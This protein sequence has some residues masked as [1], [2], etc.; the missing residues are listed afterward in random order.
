MRSVI[1]I[2]LAFGCASPPSSDAGLASDAG[3]RSDAR[4]RPDARID[5]GRVIAVG[6]CEALGDVGQWEEITPPEVSLPGPADCPFG[7]N[8]F[9]VDPVN[10][11]TV[12]LGT[13]NQGIWKST[14]CGS[15]WVHINTGRGAEALDR[16]RQWTFAIDPTQ[17]D[18]LYTN[19][20]YGGGGSNGFFKSTNGGVDW[21]EIW[22]P[23]GDPAWAGVVE[24]GFGGS[25]S[26]DPLDPRHLLISFHAR[27]LGAHA[28]ACLGESRD[29]GESWRVVDGGPGWEGGEGQA[30]WIVEGDSW[31]WGSSSNGLWR[32][33]N[34][35]ESWE[36]ID[37][38]LVGHG[39]G[40]LYRAANGAYY[41]AGQEGVLRSE[42][43]RSWSVVPS[44]GGLSYGMVGDGRTLYTSSFAVC[45]EWNPDGLQPYL[46]SPED[47]G[48]TWTEMASPPFPQG[49]SLGY[50][51]ANEILYSSNCQNGFHR[52]RMR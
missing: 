37:P 30:A 19:A 23:A 10:E 18:V 32:T 44:S 42:D 51:L 43:G 36:L 3:R 14:D 33:A 38:T 2:A 12:Y 16:A 52:V 20:G 47:D 8:S 5:A 50:D 31:L 4:A 15:S 7:T 21:D 46:T 27:C 35:G 26:M 45:F 9:V 11:G 48:L 49:G 17:P 22:P 39:G 25:I 40:Q 24:Y 1:A 34:A 29:G 13:C 28:D 41:L 6:T